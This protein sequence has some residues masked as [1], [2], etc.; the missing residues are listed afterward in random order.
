[1][2][3]DLGVFFATVG[4]EQTVFLTMSG[5][6]DRGIAGLLDYGGE[7]IESIDFLWV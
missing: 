2:V 3:C 5:F 1:M 4:D 6:V 7:L